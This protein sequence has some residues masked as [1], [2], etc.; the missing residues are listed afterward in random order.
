M[1]EFTEQ[2]FAEISDFVRKSIKSNFDD[3]TIQNYTKNFL[4]KNNIKSIIEY[5]EDYDMNINNFY[6][7]PYNFKNKEE[8]NK[9]IKYDDNKMEFSNS[10]M[11]L[12]IDTFNLQYLNNE[13]GNVVD[14][15]SRALFETIVFKKILSYS[16]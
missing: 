1:I 6:S 3:K 7:C 2:D 10:V 15:I 14:S 9:C 8:R 11:E 13:D 4:N 12:F 16:S 5:M